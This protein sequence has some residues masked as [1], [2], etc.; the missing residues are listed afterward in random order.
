VRGDQT[1]PYQKILDVVD[2]VKQAGLTKLSL[3]TQVK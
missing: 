1:L 3:D 2:L